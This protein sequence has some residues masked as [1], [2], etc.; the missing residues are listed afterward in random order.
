MRPNSAAFIS[1]RLAWMVSVWRGPSSVPT[2]VLALAASAPL[3]LVQRHVALVQQ[4]GATL[5]RT[6]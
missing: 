2:G 6:A 3:Q 4:V 5:M 1:W